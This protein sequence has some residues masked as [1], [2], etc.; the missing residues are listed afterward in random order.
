[1]IESIAKKAMQQHNIDNIIDKVISPLLRSRYQ[2]FHLG[3]AVVVSIEA[4]KFRIDKWGIN[5]YVEHLRS[6]NIN[7]ACKRHLATVLKFI[8]QSPYGF[9][10]P[11][12][13]VNAKTL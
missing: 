11:L 10:S 2:H 13:I 4:R 6:H 1:M 12:G 9:G 8:H 3:N 7:R 5:Q